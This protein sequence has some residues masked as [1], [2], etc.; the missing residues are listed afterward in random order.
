MS[1]PP[2]DWIER[3]LTPLVDA[4]VKDALARHLA[5]ASHLTP[6]D[7]IV[8][9]RIYGDER[10]L[11]LDETAV[12]NDALF[13]LSSGEIILKEYVFFGHGVS[14]LTGTHDITTFDGER[15]VGVPK[16]G[17]DI[18]I[19][20]GVW[21]STNATVLGPCHIGEHAVVAAG[22]IV[23]GD[24]APYTVV[25][26]TPA[27]PIRVIDRETR[28]VQPLPQPPPSGFAALHGA[29]H[30]R[31][32]GSEADVRQR[33]EIYLSDAE[34]AQT[35]RKVLDIG[36]GR[37][38]WLALLSER[39]IDAY[40]IDLDATMV[41]L[42]QQ[43]GLN[44]VHGDAI[45]HLLRL[46]EGSLDMVTAFHVIEHLTTDVLLAMLESARRALRPGGVLI[47]ETPDPTN[48]TMGA[49]NFYL[50]PTH[51]RP[52]PPPL[53]EFLVSASGFETV[54]VRRIHPKEDVDLSGLR[55]D[56]VDDTT[57]ET[58]RSA[59]SKGLFGTQ[60][61]AVVARVPD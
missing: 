41:E 56:G 25:A 61:Y 35:G 51:H 24:V 22:A 48:L 33:L 12:V 8:T 15:Q 4:R 49:C 21:V 37:G 59:L 9:P 32:R 52:M 20:R 43:R 57:T 29:F 44:A 38:E 42:V 16:S 23:M 2:E 5:E 11:H 28:S 1:T 34:A 18:V 55:L 6:Y 17:R 13:N 40:G 10:K 7:L 47:L 3:V 27:Q 39:G 53:T 46:D 26:G 30:D 36:P 45:R 19:E 54:E 58:V 50:D 14:V 31:F 60:D